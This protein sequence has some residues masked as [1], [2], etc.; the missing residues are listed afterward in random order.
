ML[1][2]RRHKLWPVKQTKILEEKVINHM[3]NNNDSLSESIELA[4]SFK[5][6]DVDLFFVQ[7]SAKKN[8]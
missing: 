7:L 8:L 2:L 4:K 6:P 5:Y 3:L 1:F